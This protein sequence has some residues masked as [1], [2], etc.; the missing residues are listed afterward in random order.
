MSQTA[1]APLHLVEFL[2]AHDIDAE[3]IA[4]GVPMP[5]VPAAA[6]AIGAREEQIL[7]TVLFGNKTGEYAI[8]IASGPRRIDRALLGEIVG[9]AGLRV[10][11]PD[12]VLAITGFPA[13]GVAPVGLPPEL[14]VVVDSAVMSLPIAFGGGGREDLLLEIRTADII[15]VNQARVATIV[16]G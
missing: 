16:A 9:V 2:A 8:A 4:P 10:A 1:I 3:F 7:K 5:T 14:T 12:E 6:A 11:S 13:G 15:R